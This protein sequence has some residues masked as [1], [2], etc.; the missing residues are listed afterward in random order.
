M[1]ALP[2]FDV[3]TRQKIPVPLAGRR[4]ERL[5][6]VAAEVRVDGE[7]VDRRRPVLALLEVGVGVG[8]RG[9][10]DVAALRVGE[11]EQVRGPRVVADVLE[12][13]MPSAPSVSKN[14]SC[15]FTP[16]TYGATASISPL[17]KRATAS[18]AAARPRW[19]SPRSSTGRSSGAGR[20]RRGAGS[21][22]AR[23]PRRPGRRTSARH[24]G[25]RPG[26]ATS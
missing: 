2:A 26:L 22:C 12:G 7:R 17:Q 9:R 5:D 4:R 18:A 15:G 21:A 20:G 24:R 11:H 10:A 3:L 25:A 14:A 6:R 16:T 19:M 13:A 8:A 1:S 23:P